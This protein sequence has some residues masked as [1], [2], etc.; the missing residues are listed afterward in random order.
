MKNIFITALVLCGLNAMAQVKIGDNPTNVNPN[1]VLEMES[2]NKGLLF[3]RVALTG[4]ADFAPMD[5][6]VQGMTVYNTASAGNVTPGLYTNDGSKW[7]KL[8]AP[9]A[10]AGPM[11]GK[12]PRVHSGTGAIVWQADDVVVLLPSGTHTPTITLPSARANPNRV[13]GI[14]NRT[15]LAKPLANT[16]GGDTG[17]YMDDSVTSIATLACVWFISDGTSWRVYVGR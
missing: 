15:G 5:A 14:N 16:S 11:Y 4:T 3:P 13:V 1:S 8:G 10:T 2:A 7:V 6:H 12:A 17:V 9:D